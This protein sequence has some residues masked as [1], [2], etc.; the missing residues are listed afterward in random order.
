MRCQHCG[1][2]VE[3]YDEH[4]P[5]CPSIRAAFDDTYAAGSPGLP[6][7]TAAIKRAHAAERTRR[8]RAARRTRR[9]E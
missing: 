7:L 4:F 9:F 2:Q 3:D 6:K 5:M 8:Y 1:Q